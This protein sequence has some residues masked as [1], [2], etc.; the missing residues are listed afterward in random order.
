MSVNTLRWRRLRT[1]S[2]DPPTAIQYSYLGNSFFFE[3]RLDV[4]D[5]TDLPGAV[6]TSKVR[7]RQTTGPN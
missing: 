1:K 2:Q 5:P 4:D 3:M 6:W 7:P